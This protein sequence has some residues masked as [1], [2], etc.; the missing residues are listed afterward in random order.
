MKIFISY[1]HKDKVIADELENVFHQNAI[2]LTRDVRDV[3]YGDSFSAF[4]KNVRISDY[5]LMVISDHFLK[6]EYCMYEVAEFLKDSNYDDRI[7]PIVVD[8]AKIYSPFGILQYIKYWEDRFIDLEK[9][10]NGLSFENLDYASKEAKKYKNY[11]YIISNFLDSLKDRNNKSYDELRNDDFIDILNTIG[12]ASKPIKE[13]AE[14][15][16]KEV[17]TLPG[18]SNFNEHRIIILGNGGVGKTSLVSRLVDN[19]FNLDTLST[20]GID[21][22]SW[23]IENHN[24]DL[25]DFGGQEIY[26]STY[27]IFLSQRAIYLLVIDSRSEN[28]DIERWLDIVKTFCNKTSPLFIAINKS[29]E[30]KRQIDIDSISA[31]FENFNGVIH[32]SAKTNE[33]IKELKNLL[34]NAFLQQQKIHMP[35]SWL[36]LIHEIGTSNKLFLSINEWIS[37]CQKHGIDAKQSMLVSS[38]LHD[39]GRILHFQQNQKLKKYI[40]LRP[41]WITNAFYKLFDNHEVIQHFG[42]IP[43]SKINKIWSNYSTEI[44]DVLLELIIQFQITYIH[45]QSKKLVIPELLPISAPEINWDYISNTRIRYEYNSIPKSL[46]YR[47]QARLNYLINTTLLWKNGCILN[48]DNSKALISSSS[49]KIDVYCHGNDSTDLLVKIR[50]EFNELHKFYN[51]IE[52]V[53]MTPCNC[54]ICNKDFEPFFYNYGVLVKYLSKG[55]EYITCP[56]SIEDIRIST[57]LS[58]KTSERKTN[59]TEI[60]KLIDEFSDTTDTK[61]SLLQKANKMIELKPNF[62]GI[63]INLNEIIELYLKKTKP[64]S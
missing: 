47:F 35:S 20:H 26:H 9:R 17:I 33:G 32:T 24:V 15:S 55:K 50:M 42:I 14:D 53:E 48:N 52:V 63:G 45:K 57:L 8:S 56:R 60:V 51:S 58:G 61:E 5:V 30:R 25:W 19:T 7:L 4:M 13:K 16:Y 21:I 49:N 1:S 64:S 34:V 27:E 38:F 22:K 23:N 3:K 29:D 18:V 6:S 37:V 44:Q 39:L 36:N 12:I 11:S 40:F 46:I 41:L 43:I 10:S 59:K 62:F 31:N 54:N 28:T 2:D